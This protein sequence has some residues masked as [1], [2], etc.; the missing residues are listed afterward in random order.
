MSKDIPFSI[1]GHFD[2]EGGARIATSAKC[3]GT[4]SLEDQNFTVTVV[5]ERQ[6]F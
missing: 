5:R 1:N 6:A 3:V 2:R 4:E